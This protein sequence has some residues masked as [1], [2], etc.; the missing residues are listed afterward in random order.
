M[1]ATTDQRRRMMS[2]IKGRDTGPELLLRRR[3]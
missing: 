2:R 1:L 3:L